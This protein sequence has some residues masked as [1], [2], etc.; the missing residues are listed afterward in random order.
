MRIIFAILFITN[1][2]SQDYSLIFDGADDYVE[3]PHNINLDLGMQDFHVSFDIKSEI[4]EANSFAN[5]V[6]SI[7]SEGSTCPTLIIDPS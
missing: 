1:L 4:M 6:L 7:G 5:S 3:I 2:F